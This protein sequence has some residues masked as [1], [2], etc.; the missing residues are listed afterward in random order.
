M[1]INLSSEVIKKTIYNKLKKDEKVPLT[2]EELDSIKSITLNNLDNN[3]EQ[4]S[5]DFLDFQYLKNIKELTLNGFLVN[6]EII[7]LLNSLNNLENLT[8]NHCSF[9][10]NDVIFS[11]IENLIV[12][13]SHFLNLSIFRALDRIKTLQFIN[14]SEIDIKD[15]KFAKNIESLSIHNSNIKNCS[16]LKDFINLKQL[17]ID[18]SLVDDPD[19]I[20]SLNKDIKFSCKKR[21][22]LN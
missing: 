4:I 11:S 2:I 7:K 20:D 22:Y 21:Y 12:T 5:Y 1:D 6:S 3:G 17:K 18:G 16:E 19:F 14:I 8:L 13:Y 9:E 15:I 10:A